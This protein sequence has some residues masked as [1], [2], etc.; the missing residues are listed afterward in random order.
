ML[1]NRYVLDDFDWVWLEGIKKKLLKNAIGCAQTNR[2]SPVE[3]VFQHRLAFQ[4][5]LDGQRRLASQRRCVNVS[6]YGVEHKLHDGQLGQHDQ[7]S[8]PIREMSIRLQVL[9]SRDGHCSH[10]IHRIHL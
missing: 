3:R 8:M 9:S 10:H 2:S 4:Q 7:L 6:V 5:Q 1:Y